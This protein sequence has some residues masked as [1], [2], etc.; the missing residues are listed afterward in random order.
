MDNRYC[1]TSFTDKCRL[2]YQ[3]SFFY[4][5]KHYFWCFVHI[6]WFVSSSKL[7]VSILSIITLFLCIYSKHLILLF[8][9]VFSAQ[10]LRHIFFVLPEYTNNSLCASSLNGPSTYLH[11][12]SHVC[13]MHWEQKYHT[14]KDNFKV[15]KLTI[16]QRQSLLLNF[17]TKVLCFDLQCVRLNTCSCDNQ[18]CRWT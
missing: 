2:F 1:Q 8:W 18:N 17:E 3:H 5:F 11:L 15:R 7:L 13:T 9:D 16:C 6:Y 12:S 10:C 14:N 4:H